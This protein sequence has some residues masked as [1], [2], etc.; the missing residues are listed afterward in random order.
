MQKTVL[1]T[2]C[3]ISLLANS[4]YS[5]IAPFFP[6]EAELKGVPKFLIG[7]VFSAYSLAMFLCTP[8]FKVIIDRYGPKNLL[9]LGIFC[10]SIAIL[11]FGFL[12][13]I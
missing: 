3:V 9:T 11:A 7:V 8:L 12:S 6:L 4:A 1:A 5:S 10:E 13:Q 2:L